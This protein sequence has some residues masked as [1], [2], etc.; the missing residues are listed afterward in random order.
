MIA[1]EL[2]A[3]CIFYNHKPGVEQE[4]I[5]K[6]MTSILNTTDDFI[7]RINHTEPGNVK[8]FYKKFHTDFDTRVHQ[9]CEEISQLK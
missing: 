6:V 2:F 7:K 8:E 9:L 5:Y 4:K 1:G 3:E